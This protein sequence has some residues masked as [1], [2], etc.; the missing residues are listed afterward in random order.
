MFKKNCFTKYNHHMRFTIVN[1]AAP[2]GQ[3]WWYQISQNYCMKWLNKCVI[4]WWC[5]NQFNDRCCCCW[6]ILNSRVCSI[7]Q[8]LSKQ[9]LVIKYMIQN[10]SHLYWWCVIYPWCACFVASWAW[11]MTARRCVVTNRQIWYYRAL[12][13]GLKY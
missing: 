10:D 7:I 13:N 3:A 8:R 12:I 5:L 6:F 1:S 2:G 9:F 11:Q 4:Y